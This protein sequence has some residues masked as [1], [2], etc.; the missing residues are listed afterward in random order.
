MTDN[1]ASNHIIFPRP[2]TAGDKVAIISPASPVREEFV[3]R[4]VDYLRARRFEPVVFPHVK[5]PKSGSY[6]AVFQGRLGDFIAAYT[7]P[8]IKAIVCTRGGYGT[9]HLLPHIPG[10]L[11]RENPKWLIGFSDISALHALSLSQGVASIHGPMTKHF[12][13]ENSEAEDVMAILTGK[14]M[15]EIIT[16]DNFAFPDNQEGMAEG[17]LIGGNLAVLDGLAATPFDLFAR[18]LDENAVIFIEDIA[19][20]IYKVERILYRLLMQGVLTKAKGLVIGQFTEYKP[21]ANYASMEEMISDFFKRNRLTQLPVG[22]GF[23]I[24][25]IEGNRPVIEG[26]RVRL[27][28]DKRTAKLTP[29]KL[30]K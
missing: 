24:G 18:A 9:V 10:N 16:E 14:E 13:S 8:D 5:G 15:P 22:S 20:P 6:A 2:L 19:E 12:T 21:D 28:C 26:Q 25:H 30:A 3:D 27:E 29:V 23:P 17:I 11:L 7:M 4:A 1:R